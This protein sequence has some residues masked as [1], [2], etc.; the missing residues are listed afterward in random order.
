MSYLVPAP[1]D[2]GEETTL[3]KDSERELGVSDRS[4][5]GRFF[6]PNV[7]GIAGSKLDDA[8]AD[9]DSGSIWV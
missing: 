4:R 5:H 1:V 9:S 6:L 7:N 8:V 3:E 2:K